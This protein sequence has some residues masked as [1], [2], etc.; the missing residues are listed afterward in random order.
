VIKSKGENKMGNDKIY[1]K[2]QTEILKKLD[3]GVIPWKKTW[4]GST[5]P[6][7]LISKKPYSGFNAM[8]LGCHGYDS[9]YWL[10]FKQAKKLG[11]TIKKGEKGSMA[12]YWNMYDKKTVIDGVT[13][14]ETIPFL[15]YYTVFNLVQTEGIEAPEENKIINNDP[16]QSCEDIINGFDSIPLIDFGKSPCYLPL[17]DKIGMPV[18]TSF[19]S[20]EEYYAALFHEMIHSTLHQSRL[21]RKESYAKEELVAEIGATFLCGHAGIES[22]TIDNQASY[23]DGWR[24]RIS[25]DP[26]L[27]VSAAALAQ[28]AS[29]FI[30]IS[31]PKGLKKAA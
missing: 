3:A 29:N 11:G 2:I 27:I 30:L 5:A 24:K 23:I 1:A 7:N 6:K 18:I 19:E 9:T 12:I 4:F 10:T 16:L 28:K 31:L 8:F 13:Y 25:D 15:K 26:K 17:R 20:S 14:E 22:A 21:N